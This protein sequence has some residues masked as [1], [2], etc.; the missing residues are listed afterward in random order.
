MVEA[1]FTQ[2]LLE[3]MVPV[4]SERGNLPARLTQDAINTELVK[5]KLVSICAQ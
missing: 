5:E 2:D 1:S 3:A 4:Q